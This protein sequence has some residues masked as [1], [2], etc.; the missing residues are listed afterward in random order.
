MTSG[1]EG[2]RLVTSE[3]D[4]VNQWAA[5]AGPDTLPVR[6]GSNGSWIHGGG[7]VVTAVLVAGL[8]TALMP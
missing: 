4:E 7:T 8:V 2:L 5:S 6:S 1:E 3:V